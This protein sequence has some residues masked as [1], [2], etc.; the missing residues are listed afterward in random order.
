MTGE[1]LQQ[2]PRRF[3]AWLASVVR[4]GVFWHRPAVVFALVTSAV[5]NAA[6]WIGLALAL[7]KSPFPFTLHYT[8]ALGADFF[9]KRSD[10]FTIPA[11]GLML[12]ALNA[13]LAAWL[14]DRE[15]V[16]AALVL[17]FTPL[18]QAGLAV[19]SVFLILANV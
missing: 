12:L 6:I 10:F 9:G 16:L 3:G 19:G 14:W 17:G 2:A 13:L 18:V 5:L 7:P 4:G 8:A 15:R 1:F 11:V